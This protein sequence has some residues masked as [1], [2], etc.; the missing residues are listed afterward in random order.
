MNAPSIDKNSSVPLYL[1]LANIIENKIKSGIFALDSQLPT[2]LELVK[3]FDI[4]RITVREAISKLKKQGLV[5]TKR[6]RGNFVADSH[7]LDRDLLGGH[8]FDLQIEASGYKNSIQILE[9]QIVKETRIAN[10]LGLDKNDKLRKVVRL[11]LADQTPLFIEKIFLSNSKF[12]SL[13]KHDFNDTKFIKERLRKEF[14]ITVGSYELELTPV[15]LTEQEARVL[16]IKSLPSPGLMNERITY[17][18]AGN[19]VLVSQW[20]FCQNRCKHL[21]KIRVK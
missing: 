4:S 1:Q 16:Q 12:K 11:R 3:S 21:L 15:L 6:G 2:E 14:N 17:D 10:L 13:K 8:N 19:P 20:L 7:V 18:L 9:F 5:V